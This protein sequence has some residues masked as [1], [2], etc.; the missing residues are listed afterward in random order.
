MSEKN[1]K[2]TQNANEEEL[3]QEPQSDIKEETPKPSAKADTK[4]QTKGGDEAKADTE[5]KTEKQADAPKKEET[6]YKDLYIRLLAEF[7]NFKKRSQRE[8]ES[9]GLDTKAVTVLA[10][11]P[12]LDNLDRALH[13]KDESEDSL[14]KGLELTLKQFEECLQKLGVKEI[15]A[16]DNPFD[17][18]LHNAVMHI[19]DP[20]YGE[21][22]VIEVL[23]KG[24]TVCERVIRHSMVKVAN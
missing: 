4:K 1:K 13:H 10:F 2:T 12:V 11:L 14:A 18:N 16:Q 21:N 7:D 9:I 24:Y 22:T 23:Q 6:D 8:K 17:P 5:A 3:K 20:S 19:E 15:E